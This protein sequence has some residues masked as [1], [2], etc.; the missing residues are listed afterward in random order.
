M[1]VMYLMT[2][3]HSALAADFYIDPASGNDNN[4]GSKSKPWKSL[5]AVFDGKKIQTQGWPALPY[6]AG[7]T[8]VDKHP[9]GV[10]KPGD[11]LWL[12]SG[13]YGAITISGHYNKGVI[14]IAAVPGHTPQLKT[15]LVRASSHWKVKGIH[16]SPS[17]APSYE[18]KTAVVIQSHGYNGPVR[19]ITLEDAKIFSVKDI[20]PWTASDWNNKAVNGVQ[21]SGSRITIK[22]NVVKNINFGISVTAK[23]SMIEGNLVENFSG[24]GLR[25]LGDNCVFQYNT[26]MNCYDVNDNHDDGFQSWSVGADGKVGTGVVKNVTLRGNTIIN[27]TDPNQPLRGPLQG[28]GMFDGTFDGW[29]IENNVIIVDHWH[30]ISLY[31]VKNSR[32]VNNTLMDPNSTRPGPPWIKMTKHKN[33]TAASNC[34]VRNNLTPSLSNDKAG[35]K[36]DNNIVYKDPTSLFVSPGTYDLHLLPNSAAIDKGSSDKA[37]ALDRDAYPRPFGNAIDIGAYEWHTKTN[38]PTEPHIDAGPADDPPHEVK[39]QEPTSPEQLQTESDQQDTAPVELIPTEKSIHPKD[40]SVPEHPHTVEAPHTKEETKQDNEP[41]P[42]PKGQ[43]CNC[44]VQSSSS[45]SLWLFLLVLMVFV[46]RPR[47]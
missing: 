20:K 5:Q 17:F 47:Q 31:G 8:L 2:I 40:A 44:N 37:P 33:G 21:A 46:V 15:L 1:L 22:N 38:P 27:Y 43:G 28:I 23:D 32:V 13:Y 45:D 9:G 42:T 3:G 11:T 7:M 29:V 36:E 18:R 41:L 10:V 26:V 14:T 34:L 39:P 25:G 16:V 12:L 30:G 6:K 19:D 4:S 35:V 24:D